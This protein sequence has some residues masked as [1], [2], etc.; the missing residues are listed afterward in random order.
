MDLYDSNSDPA[1][2]D[3]L[4]GHHLDETDQSQPTSCNSCESSPVPEAHHHQDDSVVEIEALQE[5]LDELNRD[6]S[7]DFSM[8]TS[9][10]SQVLKCQ[11]HEKHEQVKKAEKQTRIQQF[12]SQLA[13]MNHQ[14]DML[15]QKL[16]A[17]S[18]T[19]KSSSQ[20]AAT[21]TPQTTSHQDQSWLQQA[22]LN[23][24][25]SVLNQLDNTPV[26]GSGDNSQLTDKSNK[27]SKKCKPVQPWFMMPEQKQQCLDVSEVSSDQLSDEPLGE[28]SV[29]SSSDS[30]SSSKKSR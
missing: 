21:S 6:V 2:N 9:Q 25:D 7:T 1:V 16:L 28:S 13:E 10:D 12:Q 26:K 8:E 17:Q 4:L 14:L 19:G 22:D 24:T 15:K 20:P 30:D 18:T 11:L 23:T 29:T 3:I 27:P 5:K